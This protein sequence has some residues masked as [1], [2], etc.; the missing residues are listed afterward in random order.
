M[1]SEEDH[2]PVEVDPLVTVSPEIPEIL[3]QTKG[4]GEVRLTTIGTRGGRILRTTDMAK[5]LASQ[6]TVLGMEGLPR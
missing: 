5:T 6:I 1:A 4:L 2:S 3:N